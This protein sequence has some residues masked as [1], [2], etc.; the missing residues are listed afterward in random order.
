MIMWKTA[1]VIRMGCAPLSSVNPPYYANK[2]PEPIEVIESWGLGFHEGCVLK[3]LARW[4]EK[5]G[6]EDLEK[7]LW[8]LQRLVDKS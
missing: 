7:A 4:K 2:H 1:S 8:Y 6:K 5:G 3:Y